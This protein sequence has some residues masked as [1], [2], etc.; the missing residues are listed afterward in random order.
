[1]VPTI[2]WMREKFSEYN[3]KYFGGQLQ[4]PRFNVQRMANK[5]GT[6][7]LPGAKFSKS[8]RR[9]T[10]I[11]NTGILTLTSQYSRDEKA[12]I[13]TLLHEMVHQYV[14]TIM[15]I[16][17][18]NV[19]GREFMSIAQKL[20]ADGWKITAVTDMTETDTENNG[21]NSNGVI[22]CIFNA[23]NEESYKWWICKADEN[24]IPQFTSSVSSI[25]GATPHFYWTPTGEFEHVR[26][27]PNTL[28]GWG[29][30]TYQEAAEHVAE[31]CGINP[32]VLNPSNMKILK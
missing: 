19:H 22:L 32:S 20:A 3:R 10:S 8:T 1:M 24:Q 18:Q 16:Y 4:T 5:W 6:F 30:M 25:E 14:Y 9:I 26:S 15:Q 17:P 21:E 28:F 31:Y 2:P 29:G 7:E 12:V 23:P 13:T 27:D 11:P